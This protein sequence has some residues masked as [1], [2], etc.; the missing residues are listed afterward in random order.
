MQVPKMWKVGCRCDRNV[1]AMLKGKNRYGGDV[2]GEI[3]VCEGVA[4]IIDAG[5]RMAIT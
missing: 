4:G 3:Q 5:K 1:V 2:A